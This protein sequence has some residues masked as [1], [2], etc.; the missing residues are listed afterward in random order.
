MLKKWISLI[1]FVGLESVNFIFASNLGY[2]RSILLFLFGII[3]AICCWISEKEKTK[4]NFDREL[5]ETIRTNVVEKSNTERVKRQ[6]KAR[7][8]DIEKIAEAFLRNVDSLPP[9]ESEK[10]NMDKIIYYSDIL[11]QRND[12]AFSK[13]KYQAETSPPAYNSSEKK[14]TIDEKDESYKLFL[15]LISKIKDGNN[16]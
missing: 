3:P 5:F 2:V 16:E 7:S 8:N 4:R 11:K 15:Q 13:I 10:Q 1:W 9:E 6:V 12:E 14:E